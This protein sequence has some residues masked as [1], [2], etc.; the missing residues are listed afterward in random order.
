MLISASVFV[1]GHTYQGHPAACAAALEVQR[2]IR[3]DNLLSNIQGT[4]QLLAKLLVRLVSDHP[5]VGDIR[6]RGLFWGIEFVED[7]S[8]KKAFRAEANIAMEISELGLTER[9]GIAVYPGTGTVD[10]NV[11]DHIIIAPPFNVTEADIEFVVKTVR[12]LIG[13][14]FAAKCRERCGS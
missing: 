3:C 8:K 7:K 13:D 12:K 4:G 1:H 6:G 9:Y 2:I 14:Y 10:G 5:N 11:G